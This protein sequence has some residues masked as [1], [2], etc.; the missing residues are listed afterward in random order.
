MS[1][2][3]D[4]LLWPDGFWYFTEEY[5]EAV[6]SKSDDFVILREGTPEYEEFLLQEGEGV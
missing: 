1:H 3:E 5:E 4:I 2:P 6:S